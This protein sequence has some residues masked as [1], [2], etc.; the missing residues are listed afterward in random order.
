ME[1]E[2][3]LRSFLAKA[4]EEDVNQLKAAMDQLIDPVTKFIALDKSMDS[5]EAG[6]FE[7][8]ANALA[9]AQYIVN[10]IMYSYGF[11]VCM[12]NHDDEDEDE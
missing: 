4:E 10:G 3:E 1:E 8:L 7:A 12:D 9:Q 5:I 6:D 2:D 11:E